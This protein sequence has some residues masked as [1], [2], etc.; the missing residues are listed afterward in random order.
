MRGQIATGVVITA[1]VVILTALFGYFAY[2]DKALEAK[3]KDG[4]NLNAASVKRIENSTSEIQFNLKNFLG[5]KYVE[6][7]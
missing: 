1:G 4:D 5:S 7:K 2:S 3:I 6:L